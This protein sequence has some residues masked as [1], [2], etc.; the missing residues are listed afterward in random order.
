MQVQSQ[1][2][3]RTNG[4]VEINVNLGIFV[5]NELMTFSRFCELYANVKH[6]G[7]NSVMY[8]ILN[9]LVLLNTPILINYMKKFFSIR[10]HANVVTRFLTF[11][12][13]LVIYLS[14]KLIVFI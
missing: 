11:V 5:G 12:I 7:K 6:I 1:E 4:L 13:K 3:A 14:T 10:Y 9:Y 2:L 8:C